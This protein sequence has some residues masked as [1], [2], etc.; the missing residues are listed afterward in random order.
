MPRR[1][2][3]G[4]W[5]L[6]WVKR[7]PGRL[8]DRGGTKD[9]SGFWG[10]RREKQDRNWGE[11]SEAPGM[12]GGKISDRRSLPAAQCPVASPSPGPG[13]KGHLDLQGK[14]PGRTLTA[15]SRR[16]CCPSHG[17]GWWGRLSGCWQMASPCPPCQDGPGD[18]ELPPPGS[19][20]SRGC[21]CKSRFYYY[22]VDKAD[23]SGDG[24]Y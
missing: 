9:R 23:R 8:S 7:G 21:A 12:V 19:R 13:M 6:P 4:L 1:A 5:L 3:E 10:E 15:P 14:R 20:P 22:S 16:P 18:R 24:C 17:W 2:Q 11:A